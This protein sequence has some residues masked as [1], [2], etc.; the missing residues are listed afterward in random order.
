MKRFGIKMLSFYQKLDGLTYINLVAIK[1]I[2][3]KRLQFHF[4][5]K[6]AK[7]VEAPLLQLNYDLN[8]ETFKE[9]FKYCFG[10][11]ISTWNNDGFH[12]IEQLINLFVCF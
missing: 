1:E 8:T 6:K 4:C 10:I 11:S 3:A 9:E 7:F 5:F 12:L 2:L